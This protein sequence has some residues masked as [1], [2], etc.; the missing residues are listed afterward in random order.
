MNN[1]ENTMSTYKLRLLKVSIVIASLVAGLL[2]FPAT[3]FAGFGIDPGKVQVDNLHPGAEAEY[4]IAVYNQ[5][6]Y[7]TTFSINPRI[8]DYTKD[9]REA[10][11]Y[12]DWITITPVEVTLKPS[13]TDDVTVLIVMPKDVDYSN[14]ESEVW[15]SFKEKNADDMVQIEIISR[16][17]INTGAET[18]Q[19]KAEDNPEKQPLD[20]ADTT[21]Q[22]GKT[23]EITPL[24][25]G[26][27]TPP[28]KSG[29]DIPVA[30]LPE[31]STSNAPAAELSESSGSNI[32]WI[33]FGSVAGA[34]IVFEGMY[35]FARKRRKS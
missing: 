29:A 28:E 26:E 11:P 16:L 5:N 4:T 25:P 30:N 6:D 9:G 7:E 1:K 20:V 12:L 2:I 8:P 33:I 21:F 13:D 34:I 27:A 17:L 15:L 19:A 10:F 24:Q 32:P 35:L 3:A 14:K 31:E 18:S 23:A 22:P